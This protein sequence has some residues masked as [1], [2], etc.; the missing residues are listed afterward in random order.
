MSTTR[1]A[2]AADPGGWCVQVGST[3]GPGSGLTGGSAFLFF[4]LIFTGGRMTASEK[5][6]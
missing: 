2:A 5:N 1:M 3:R 4:Y 6:D